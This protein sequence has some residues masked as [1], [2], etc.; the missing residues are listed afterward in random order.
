MGISIDC[1][2]RWRRYLSTL[3]LVLLSWVPWVGAQADPGPGTLTDWREVVAD[4]PAWSFSHDVVGLAL[5]A[6]AEWVA[7]VLEPGQVLV[8]NVAEERVGHRL[9]VSRI[10]RLLGEAVR[11]Q[12][13]G[14]SR[15]LAVV[16]TDRYLVFD[17]VNDERILDAD[18]P[19][20]FLSG[21][22]VGEG[23]VVVFSGTEGLPGQMPVTVFDLD[24][25][26]ETAKFDVRGLGKGWPFAVAMSPDLRRV[27]TWH[28]FVTGSNSFRGA[29]AIWRTDD[30]GLLKTFEIPALT[31]PRGMGFDGDGKVWGVSGGTRFLWDPETGRELE[32]YEVPEAGQILGDGRHFV[33]RGGALLRVGVGPDPS[34]RVLTGLPGDVEL[35][36]AAGAK[37]RV[38]VL[39]SSPYGGPSIEIW[40]TE[41]QSPV[42]EV[43]WPLV[44]ARV[45]A[46]SPGGGTVASGSVDG[47]VRLWDVEGNRLEGEESL[48]RTIAA[49]TF[50]GPRRL[51][52]ATDEQ[53]L[54]W[55]PSTGEVRPLVDLATPLR[56]VQRRHRP[57]GQFSTFSTER[58]GLSNDG[59]LAYSRGA[60]V[61]LW[62]EDETPI[63]VPGAALDSLSAPRPAG[64]DGP[65]TW[66]VGNASLG[67]GKR[68]VVLRSAELSADGG[69]LVVAHSHR[70]VILRDLASGRDVY[71]VVLDEDGAFRR[72]RL[73]PDRRR[74]VL[75]PQQTHTGL[76]VVDLET[77][78]TQFEVMPL[79]PF[80]NIGAFELSRDG[81]TLWVGDSKT[82][83]LRRFDVET[84]AELARADPEPLMESMGPH[85]SVEAL[86]SFPD[87]GL[88]AS[89]YDDG[90]IRLWRVGEQGLH[91]QSYW[92]GGRGGNWLGCAPE[93]GCRGSTDG[94][95]LQR[96]GAEGRNIP[97]EPAELAS[98]ETA[99]EAP[100]IEEPATEPVSSAGES[101]PRSR[102]ALTLVLLLA[103]LGV[104]FIA[105]LARRR[106]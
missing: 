40:D 68:E 105:G 54:V 73:H 14:G 90:S 52:V 35:T 44:P 89:V 39:E 50:W 33:A 17:L 59:K 22:F 20:L 102:W 48:G 80:G 36:A 7:A 4:L 65:R 49:L 64:E 98:F 15:Y 62:A 76:S 70:G 99:P 26:R 97:I 37:P 13:A 25:R 10:R 75:D 78:D 101:S 87:G 88:L 56:E 27:A 71:R 58:L 45:V 47:V 94:T 43:G 34:K 41:Q 96:L 104:L 67:Y 23:G 28:V 8:W 6:D 11:I 79:A 24:D 51:A 74:L 2:R 18:A 31:E 66:H 61:H 21:F 86:A 1:L 91:L 32:R 85:L 84:G 93:G 83:T 72:V 42:G 46:V 95:F 81:R 38:A 55:E 69:W 57:L 63:D 106:T 53:V 77:G 30:G 12:F 82:G 29:L 92:L 16:H 9:E 3:G 60:E 100:A 19:G 103:V 5:S